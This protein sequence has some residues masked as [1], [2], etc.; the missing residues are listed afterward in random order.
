MLLSGDFVDEY[1]Y[2]IREL[3]ECIEKY[4]Q[5][6]IR[7][8]IESVTGIIE[9]LV[10]RYKLGAVPEEDETYYRSRRRTSS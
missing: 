2:W 9:A 10:R 5:P 3:A 7:A 1:F 4:P 8:D 6:I